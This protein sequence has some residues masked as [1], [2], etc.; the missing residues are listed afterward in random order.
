MRL[1][2]RQVATARVL[3][4][5]AGPCDL[6]RWFEAAGSGPGLLVLDGLIAVDFRVC[7]RTA[8]ELVGPGDLLQPAWPL[9][10]NMLERSDA[11]QALTPTRFALL[12]TEFAERVRPWPQI[13]AALLR[14]AGRR[15]ADLDVLRAITSQPRLEARLVLLLW[16][17]AARWGRVEPAGIRVPLPLTH[18]MLGQLVG[19]ERPSISH[20]LGRLAHAGVV[21]GTAG[22]WHLHGTVTEHLEALVER[23]ARLSERPARNG[24]SSH[25]KLASG[26]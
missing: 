9:A 17:L 16:H 13:A 12:D 23:P 25:S 18:R 15:M 7:N 2:A 8:T 1:A 20:A 4:A 19:A 10:E 21:T 22:D 5:E 14:R 24:R 3:D 6:S 26:G 11:W